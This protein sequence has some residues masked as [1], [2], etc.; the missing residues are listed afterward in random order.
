MSVFCESCGTQASDQAKFCHGCGASHTASAA[1]H[2]GAAGPASPGPSHAGNPRRGLPPAGAA[3]TPGAA[4][5]ADE[6]IGDLKRRWADLE[7]PAKAGIAAAGGLL[8]LIVVVKILPAL[9]AAMGIG[10]FL[11]LLFVPYWAPTIVAFVRKHPSK[12]GIFALNFFLGWTFIGWVVSFVWAMSDNTPRAASQ[13][14][15]VNTNV[16]TVGMPP[17]YS[18]GDIVGGQR[19]DGSGWTPLP[20][21]PPGA[22]ESE[23][24]SA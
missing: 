3:A 17:H 2:E 23:R 21:P 19:F 18:V 16:G 8:G 12:F 6:Q 10:L 24:V 7:T 13:T 1:S 15:V 4:F 9:L 14:V 22:P 20:S 5:S 11:V